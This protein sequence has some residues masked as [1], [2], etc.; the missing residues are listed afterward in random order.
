MLRTVLATGPQINGTRPRPKI[1]GA[2]ASAL[3][4]RLA[5]RLRVYLPQDPPPQADGRRALIVRE[6]VGSVR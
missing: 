4:F 6:S 2:T 1:C 3:R 5:P